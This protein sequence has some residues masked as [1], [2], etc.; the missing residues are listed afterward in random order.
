MKFQDYQKCLILPTKHKLLTLK[1]DVGMLCTRQQETLKNDDLEEFWAI[2]FSK[3]MLMR[4]L[5]FE[6][7]F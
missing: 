1:Y 3:H 2:T 7:R 6:G 5:C 4:K